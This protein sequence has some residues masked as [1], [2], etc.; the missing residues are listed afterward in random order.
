MRLCTSAVR[1]NFATQS[2]AKNK[3][4][5]SAQQTF[6]G[7]DVVAVPG[8]VLFTLRRR[9]GLWSRN[10]SHALRHQLAKKQLQQCCSARDSRFDGNLVGEVLFSGGEVC[11]HFGS[12]PPV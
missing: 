8:G 9:S 3:P 7:A 6:S 12:L 4:E 11:T 1:C 10:P 2:R 5:Q